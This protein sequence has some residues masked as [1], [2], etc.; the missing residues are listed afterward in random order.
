MLQL[1]DL[2]KHYLKEVTPYKQLQEYEV[3]PPAQ[4]DFKTYCMALVD[5]P[6][7]PKPK[8]K[9]HIA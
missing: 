7:Y 2:R 4:V 5:D 6:A 3:A 1:K 8:L 9:H